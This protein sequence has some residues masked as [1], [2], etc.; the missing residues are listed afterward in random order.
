MWLLRFLGFGVHRGVDVEL[1]VQN[2][3]LR[4]MGLLC[5]FIRIC[6]LVG[7]HLGLCP[8]HASQAFKKDLEGRVRVYRALF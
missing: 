5:G 1:R 7:L 8:M 2:V 6:R 3:W 4:F